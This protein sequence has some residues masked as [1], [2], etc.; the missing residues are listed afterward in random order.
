MIFRL[1]IGSCIMLMFSAA[2]AQSPQTQNINVTVGSQYQASSTYTCGFSVA[3]V[4][5][6]ASG[7]ASI[8]TTTSAEGPNSTMFT[9]V[10]T[11]VSPGSAV[12]TITGSNTACFPGLTLK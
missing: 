9:F 1:T 7:I 8:R 5:N 2:A 11:G 6:T 10:V 3:S 4:T 12:I